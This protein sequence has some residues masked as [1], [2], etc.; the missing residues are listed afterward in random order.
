MNTEKINLLAQGGTPIADYSARNALC[1]S[2]S[3]PGVQTA[4][5]CL[6]FNNTTTLAKESAGFAIG[7]A[8]GITLLVLGVA[9]I[10]VMTSQGN[11]K[12]L[13]GAKELFFS[14]LSALLMIILAGFVLRLI[15]VQILGLF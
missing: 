10:R 11:P 5:G 13:Q 3:D 1:G 8:G 6:H 14:A 2:D 15:G 7:I 9:A 12:A 4:L